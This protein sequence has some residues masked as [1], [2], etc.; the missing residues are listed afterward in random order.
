MKKWIYN[1]FSSKK[2]P[3]KLTFVYDFYGKS[4]DDCLYQIREDRVFDLPIKKE[5]IIKENSFG[6]SVESSINDELREEI[7]K[8][9]K[10]KLIEA[11]KEA[12]IS[13]EDEERI[14]GDYI[15]AVQCRIHIKENKYLSFEEYQKM[16]TEEKE[17]E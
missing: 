8:K 15:V 3:T 2:I 7:V 9:E 13:L 17:A 12:Y 11:R 1:L 5:F 6:F 14:T 10:E 16:K 4:T